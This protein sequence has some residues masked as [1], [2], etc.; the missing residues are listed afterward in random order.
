MVFSNL[1]LA[2]KI[3]ELI[4]EREKLERK[5]EI[6]KE[7]K[8]NLEAKISKSQTEDFFEEK[9]REQGYQRPGEKQVV[10]LPPEEKTEKGKNFFQNFFDWIRNRFE[11]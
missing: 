10:I 5:I 1:R 4:R 7:K 6:L 9:L 3:E 2:G 11:K 8:K